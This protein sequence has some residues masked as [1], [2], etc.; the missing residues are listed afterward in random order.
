MPPCVYTVVMYSPKPI[1]FLK[2]F[3]VY[4]IKTSSFKRRPH[5]LKAPTYIIAPLSLYKTPLFQLIKASSLIDAPDN[6]TYQWMDWICS[7]LTVYMLL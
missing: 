6:K 3:K 7:L 2:C 4:R 1:S 5:L